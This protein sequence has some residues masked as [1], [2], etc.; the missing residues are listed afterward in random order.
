MP[1]LKA[2]IE[3]LPAN[4]VMGDFGCSNGAVLAQFFDYGSDFHGLEMS[5]SGLAQG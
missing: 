3:G 1:V 2:E 5:Q 4:S